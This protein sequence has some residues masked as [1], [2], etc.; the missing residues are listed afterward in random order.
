MRILPIAA[1]LALLGSAAVAQTEAPKGYVGAY[2]A[3]DPNRPFGGPVPEVSLGPGL[4]V[5]GPG[6]S[7]QSSQSR[8]LQQGCPRNRRHDYL[9]RDSR[10]DW[11]KRRFPRRLHYWRITSVAAN[12]S[13]ISGTSTRSGRA[14]CLSPCTSCALASISIPGRSSVV[15]DPRL[16]AAPRAS[17]SARMRAARSVRHVESRLRLRQ[18]FELGWQLSL[19]YRATGCPLLDR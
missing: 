1:V 17:C 8:S 3:D 18:R 2:G 15:R 12:S 14:T 11:K 16:R 4:N 5:S 13:L 6:R 9:R 7:N 19:P 10:P